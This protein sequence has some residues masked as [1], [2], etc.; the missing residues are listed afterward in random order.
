MFLRS[1]M[2]GFPPLFLCSLG[3]CFGSGS[4]T[5]SMPW[6]WCFF[7]MFVSLLNSF[8]RA[9]SILCSRSGGVVSSLWSWHAVI[10]AQRLTPSSGFSIPMALLS[11]IYVASIVVAVC[12]LGLVYSSRSGDVSFFFFFWFDLLFL[13][14]VLEDD[15]VIWLLRIFVGVVIMCQNCEWVCISGVLNKVFFSLLFGYR[16]PGF[17]DMIEAFKIW[18]GFSCW[19]FRGL[20]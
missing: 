16:F 7:W 15:I 3:L 5:I 17:G 1:S 9:H 19:W 11:S 6:V 2:F 20:C 8:L 18:L 10:I 4:R 13:W 12:V 14:L